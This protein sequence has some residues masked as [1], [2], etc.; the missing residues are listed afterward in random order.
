MVHVLTAHVR[1]GLA[2]TIRIL[3]ARIQ[4]CLAHAICVW[5]GLKQTVFKQNRLYKPVKIR[6]KFLHYTV[7]RKSILY[8]NCI[9]IIKRIMSFDLKL[10]KTLYLFGKKY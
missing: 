8:Q 4:V 2:H 3:M 9:Q 6:L 5:I 1:A 10:Y 7:L